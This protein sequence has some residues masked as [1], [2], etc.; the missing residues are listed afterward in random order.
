VTRFH[1]EYDTFVQPFNHTYAEVLEL[2]LTGPDGESV[3]TTPLIYNPG[4]D[5]GPIKAPLI[6]TPVDDARGMFCC[7]YRWDLK[8]SFIL[9][10]FSNGS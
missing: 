10:C 8:K 7:C 4:T 6:D 3:S 1:P 9:W 5:N 2:S